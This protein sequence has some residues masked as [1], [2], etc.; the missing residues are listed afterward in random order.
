VSV[1]DFVVHGTDRVLEDPVVLVSAPPRRPQ[2]EDKRDRAGDEPDGGHA[3]D[4][5]GRRRDPEVADG[6]PTIAGRRRVVT[7]ETDDGDESD[8]GGRDGDAAPAPALR[9]GSGVL[10]FD[11]G[12]S[13]DLLRR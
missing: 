10:S 13:V 6:R 1:S 3:D 8:D 2:E 9:P 12:P 11:H 5:T 7:R 4:R